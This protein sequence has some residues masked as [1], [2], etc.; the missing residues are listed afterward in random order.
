MKSM[1][2]F[3]CKNPIDLQIAKIQ[4][5]FIYWLDDNFCYWRQTKPRKVSRICK[6]EA[7]QSD[8]NDKWWKWSANKWHFWTFKSFSTI[9]N[10]EVTQVQ[11]QWNSRT[12]LNIVV[13]N[14][15]ILVVACAVLPS[16][17]SQYMLYAS[18]L[19]T[20]H[21]TRCIDKLATCNRSGL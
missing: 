15:I 2:I 20:Y 14:V 10:I 6:N 7:K 1:F 11:T 5:Q 19:Q 9:L 3:K 8:P 12:I 17:R 16:S 18:V 21:V 13:P 4:F